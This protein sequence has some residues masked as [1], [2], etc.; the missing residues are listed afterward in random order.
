[1]RRKGLIV[2][3]LFSAAAFVAAFCTFPVIEA[4]HHPYSGR[5]KNDIWMKA[6][7]PDSLLREGDLILR[8]GRGFISN[9]FRSFSRED[10]KYSHA[11]FVIFNRGKPFVVHAIGEEKASNR[12]RM[13]P[14]PEFCNP[15]DIHSFAVYRY[16]LRDDE[17]N[18]LCN[19][20]REEYRNELA[21]DLDFSLDTD[22]LVYCSEFIYKAIISATH[23]KNYLPLS[24]IAGFRYVSIDNLYLN[25]HCDSVYRYQY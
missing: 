14:M 4:E 11:G 12:L 13:D 6:V 8:H 19:I 10:K 3:L 18:R 15:S 20:V 5:E 24:G 7:P 21:F 17:R 9:A 1:M 2:L 23:N 16:R 22:S 25:E